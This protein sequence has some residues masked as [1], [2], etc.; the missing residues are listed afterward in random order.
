MKTVLPALLLAVGF[1]PAPVI[2]AP[3]D[4]AFARALA[5]FET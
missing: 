5:L 3:P 4:G 1:V 2:S